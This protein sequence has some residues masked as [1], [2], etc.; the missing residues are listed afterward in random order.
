MVP[1][2]EDHPEQHVDHAQDDAQL[3]LEGV[4]ENNLV[5]GHLQIGT[6]F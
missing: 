4:E 1:V 6:N 3:H 5:L 2:G